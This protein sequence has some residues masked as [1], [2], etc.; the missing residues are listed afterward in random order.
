[1][2]DKGRTL[3]DKKLEEME[4]HLSAI[5][6][7]AHKELSEKYENYILKFEEADEKKR[8]LLENGKITER[9]YQ[10]WRKG[11]IATGSYWRNM[12]EQTAKQLLR[13]NEIALAYVNDQLPEIYAINYNWSAKDLEMQIDNA[14]SFELVDAQT[15]KNLSLIGDKSLLPYKEIDP[16][17]DIPWNMQKINAEVLQGILQGESIPKIAKRIR[18][19]ENM[20][21]VSAIRSARTMVTGTENKGRQDRYS[22]ADAKGIILQKEWLETSD[23]RTRHS[24]RHKPEGVGGEIVDQDQ[25]FSNGLMFPGDPNGEP[26]EVYNCRCTLVAIVKGFKKRGD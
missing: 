8:K 3:T 11:Q 20:N 13:V 1:M 16:T 26:S 22:E 24:H 6:S 4:R 19:V 21:K 9:E 25:P 23:N 15:V 14:I 18:N 12:K 17:K 2:S 7:R 10:R 5:Y